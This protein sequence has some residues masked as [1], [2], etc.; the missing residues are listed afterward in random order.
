MLRSIQK[1][2]RTSGYCLAHLLLHR[3]FG[4]TVGLGNLNGVCKKSS[5]TAWTS[6]NIEDDDKTVNTI[7]HEVGHNFGAE[8]DGGNSSTYAG[9]ST[10][11]TMGIMGGLDTETFSTCSLS[12]MHHRLQQVYREEDDNKCFTVLDEGSSSGYTMDT[13]DMS[14]YSTEC[15]P[16]PRTA[17][18][19]DCSEQPPD[20]PE[21]PDPPEPVCG[22]HVVD[23]S[24]DCDCGMTWA[25][26]EDPCCYPATLTP[27]DLAANSSAVPCSWNQAP[28]CQASPAETFWKFGL[29]A[30]FLAILLLAIISK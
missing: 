25:D 9:C 14:Y 19:E 22:D 2:A 26:C 4:C 30:P 21:I 23:D 3:N 7:A 29:I 27:A 10:E 28:L 20:P 24:E 5:N 18:D 12:A 1:A 8:H 16:E 15:P 6:V 13:K 17:A 11:D